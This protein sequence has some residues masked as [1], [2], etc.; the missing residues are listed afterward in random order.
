MIVIKQIKQWPSERRADKEDC[1]D[2]PEIAV[3]ALKAVII[4]VK[5]ALMTLKAITGYL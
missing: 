3:M 2:D 5:S 1:H 4:I